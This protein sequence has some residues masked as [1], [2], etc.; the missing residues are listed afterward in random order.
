MAEALVDK[1][2]LLDEGNRHA[3]IALRGNNQ[4]AIALASN[5]I[6]HQRIKHIDIQHHYIR[7]E[8]RKIELKYVPTAKIIADG[9][10]KSFLSMKLNSLA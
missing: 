6:L 7:D 3:Q 2:G 1:L 8:A 5:P 4:S 9:L 10:I